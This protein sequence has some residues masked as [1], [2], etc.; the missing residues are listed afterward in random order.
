MGQ[1]EA[2]R[3]FPWSLL[4]EMTIELLG[5]LQHGGQALG[6]QRGDDGAPGRP[7]WVDR[8]DKNKQPP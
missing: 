6:S 3:S 2:H 7:G 8:M 1:A 4:L 5:V